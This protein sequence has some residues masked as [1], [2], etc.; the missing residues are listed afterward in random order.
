MDEEMQAL[1]KAVSAPPKPERLWQK[2]RGNQ[3]LKPLARGMLATLAALRDQIARQRDLPR[4]W[5]YPDAVLMN[6]AQTLGKPSSS[7]VDYPR[8]I[9]PLKLSKAQQE[10]LITALKQVSQKPKSQLPTSSVPPALSQ[11]EKELLKSWS[12]IVDAVAV[13]HSITPSRL[14]NR[15]DLRVYLQS[16]GKKG[17]ISRGWRQQLLAERLAC[18]IL[19]Q[20]SFTPSL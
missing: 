7:P 12:Q 20:H 17:R 2:I 1:R 18:D 5:V 13:E 10:Q 14:A 16:D 11:S 19:N 8:Q 6:I 9:A 15:S 3:T 4:R